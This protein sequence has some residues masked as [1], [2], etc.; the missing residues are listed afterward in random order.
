MEL[1]FDIL[2]FAFFLIGFVISLKLLIASNLEKLFKQGRIAE[3]RLTYVILSLI[4]GF[5][6]ASSIVKITEVSYNIL[7]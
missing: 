3:I 7:L 1:V 2:Y 6:F 4:I 5:L